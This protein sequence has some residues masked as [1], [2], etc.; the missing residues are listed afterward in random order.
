MA[1][2]CHHKTV[3]RPLQTFTVAV[4]AYTVAVLNVVMVDCPFWDLP[5]YLLHFYWEPNHPSRHKKQKLT[6]VKIITKLT[7]KAKCKSAVIC[8]NWP[9]V[10]VHCQAQQSWKCYFRSLTTT[11]TESLVTRDVYGS[12]NISKWIL[13]S[14]V[15]PLR[16]T[17]DQSLQ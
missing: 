15:T 12:Q 2:I 14:A 5:D 13:P 8:S 11:H 10:P 6:L 3:H 17:W 16:S 4:I 1:T 9:C 7:E